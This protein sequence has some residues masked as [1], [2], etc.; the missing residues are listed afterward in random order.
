MC[1]AIMTTNTS[2]TPPEGCTCIE[3]QIYVYN[4]IRILGSGRFHAL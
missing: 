4:G 1:M 2:G 3:D